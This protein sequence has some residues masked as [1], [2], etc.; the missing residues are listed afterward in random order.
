[1]RSVRPSCWILGAA[2]A[3]A[4]G[5][6]ATA[7]VPAC[8]G[9]RSGALQFPLRRAGACLVDA[10]GDAVWLQGEAAWSLVVQLDD[11]ELDR[12]LADRRARGVNALVVNLIE[13]RGLR[14]EQPFV[15]RPPRNV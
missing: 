7:P 5:A 6:R 15:R 1:M 9:P 11:A 13:H 14:S 10:A 8:A 4:C 3:L 12:Y 2:L